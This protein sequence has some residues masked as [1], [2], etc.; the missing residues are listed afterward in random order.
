[1]NTAA[2]E[3]RIFL[4]KPI[5]QIQDMDEDWDDIYQTSLSVNCTLLLVPK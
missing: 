5:N 2:K 1:M 4:L 3:D